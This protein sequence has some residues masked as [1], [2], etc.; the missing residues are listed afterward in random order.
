MSLDTKLDFRFWTLDL[1]GFQISDFGFHIIPFRY[2]FR[3]QVSSDFGFQISDF[4]LKILD[5]RFWICLIYN[6]IFRLTLKG[7]DTKAKL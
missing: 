2:F 5:L 7:F 6:F 1:G 4:G 3:L